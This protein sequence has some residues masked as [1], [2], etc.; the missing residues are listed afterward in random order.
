MLRTGQYQSWRHKDHEIQT[1]RSS[2]VCGVS[3]SR[4]YLGASSC[5]ALEIVH[6]SGDSSAQTALYPGGFSTFLRADGTADTYG[7]SANSI[8]VIDA[9]SFNVVP[10]WVGLGGNNFQITIAVDNL[11]AAPNFSFIYTG[12]YALIPIPGDASVSIPAITGT[13]CPVGDASACSNA[14][15]SSPGD[16]VATFLPTISSGSSSGSLDGF[17]TDGGLPFD[18]TVNA[19]P[20]FSAPPVPGQ[21]AG[22]VSLASNP[23]FNGSACFA[24]TSGV[25]N[26]LTI[27]PDLSTQ[28]GILESIYA[29][30]LDPQ[31]VPT[32]LV[33]NGFSANLYTTD[34]NTNPY[35]D[36][37]T[38]TEWAVAAAIGEDDPTVGTTGVANDGTNSVMVQ[39][40]G[41]LGGACDS[42]GGADAPFHFI[43]GKPFV[44]GHRKHHQHSR[45][46]ERTHERVRA[47][48]R[49]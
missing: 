14:T 20:T 33:L 37:I 12:T 30:G 18:S 39:F 1:R 35:A 15:Q 40:Y 10:T 11:G 31:G 19:T 3:A 43:S 8:C 24:T 27:N 46:R 38:S 41:V 25:V 5:W 21:I 13:Y 34:T 26:P 4:D 28:S 23:T 9:E 22:T 6:M 7:T 47:Q 32:T 29:E 42:A 49:R 2:G 45:R 36:Q 48:L 17:A 16:F 44:H